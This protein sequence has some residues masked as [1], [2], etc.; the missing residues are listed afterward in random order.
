MCN[1]YFKILHLKLS[2]RNKFTNLQIYK[3]ILPKQIHLKMRVPRKLHNIMLLKKISIDNSKKP[4]TKLKSQY[5]PMKRQNENVL[6]P[7]R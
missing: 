4:V 3:L 6:S 5:S 2:F 7:G 1:T